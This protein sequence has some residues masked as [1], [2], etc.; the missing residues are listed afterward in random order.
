VPWRTIASIPLGQKSSE[1]RER[2]GRQ[3]D[4]TAERRR[5]LEIDVNVLLALA[6]VPS[7]ASMRTLRHLEQAASFRVDVLERDGRPLVARRFATRALDTTRSS[8]PGPEPGDARLSSTG[9]WIG[10]PALGMAPEGE[11]SRSTTPSGSTFRPAVGR[12]SPSARERD[13]V[14][15]H[16]VTEATEER[17]ELDGRLIRPH[18]RAVARLPRR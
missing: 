18:R 8:H 17:P 2:D 15:P 6:P 10:S 1:R 9:A 13:V 14:D 4:V 7:A 11:R 3:L 5:Q 12:D 16:V